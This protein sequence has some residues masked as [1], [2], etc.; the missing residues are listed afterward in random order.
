MSE[1]STRIPDVRSAIRDL[2]AH[3]G[4]RRMIPDSLR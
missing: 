2:A 3:R 1:A 4:V